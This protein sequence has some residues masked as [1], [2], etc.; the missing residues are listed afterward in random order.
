MQAPERRNIKGKGSLYQDK[1]GYYLYALMHEG[2]RIVRSL[3]TKD[4]EEAEKNVI[5]V[6]REFGAR[7]ESGE[8]APPAV[9]NFTV[10][11]LL[12]RYLEYMHD[13]GKKSA[14]MV[15]LTIG[16]IERDRAFLPGRKVANLQTADFEDHRKR[17]VAR[18][19]AQRTINYRFA[20]IRA[21]LN[22]E[23]KR[24]PSCVGK[25]PYI[26]FV[27]E[28]NARSGFLEYADHQALLAEL[29]RSLKALFA[30]AFH[31]GCRMGE[32]L[33][34]R[35]SDI[36]WKNRVI[37]L[38]VTKNGRKRNLPFWGS[39]E[40]HLKVQ[41]QYR[42]E[43]HPESEFLFFWM[44]EDMEID[45]GGTRSVPGAP[46]KDFRWSWSHAVK[47]AHAANKNVKA[48]LLFHDLRRSAVR[49][50]IQEAGIPEAQAMLIS[51][52]E[53]QSMLTRYNIVSL[54][55]VQDAGAKL[56][57]WIKGAVTSKPLL[58]TGRAR[59]KATQPK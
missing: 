23:A 10:G 22:L 15:R 35:W 30:V 25:V 48:D 14:D 3:K 55:N 39:I 47:R 42:D 12:Q 57:A 43:N 34:M 7:I 49:I 6:M 9:K 11:Q 26:P 28:N 56:D 13:N 20:L 58:V 46:I 59:Q 27:A 53:T 52:H 16:V 29:P 31:S 8:L 21:A 50:M 32:L 4:P 24:T 37:R 40:D 33:N 5:K 17:E 54:K 38:P 44:E 2:K 19:V 41:K 1:N 18:G 36:D 45:H 51:G